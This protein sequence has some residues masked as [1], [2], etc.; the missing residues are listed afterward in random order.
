MKKLISLFACLLALSVLVCGCGGKQSAKESHFKKMEKQYGAVFNAK[1]IELKVLP[2]PEGTV[3]QDQG[4][5]TISW[6]S[7]DSA[8]VHVGKTA[9][10]DSKGL[11]SETD[12]LSKGM[13]K[14]NITTTYAAGGT[15]VAKQSASLEADGVAAKEIPLADAEAKLKK[16]GVR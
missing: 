1:R 12:M 4:N 8:A 9:V 13:E 16:W 7:H 10:Y 2:I 11:V 14:L 3:A 15:A 6:F 5:K